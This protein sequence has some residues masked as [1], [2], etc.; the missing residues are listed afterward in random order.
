M[1]LCPAPCRGVVIPT[2][3]T[4]HHKLTGLMGRQRSRCAC[5]IPTFTGLIVSYKKYSVIVS[6]LLYSAICK[7]LPL[8]LWRN[9]KVNSKSWRSSKACVSF[10]HSLLDWTDGVSTHTHGRV[11]STSHSMT[12]CGKRCSLQSISS[13]RPSSPHLRTYTLTK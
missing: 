7:G 2:P 3:P 1:F 4:A 10:R 5:A 13:L 6:I 8:R 11:I 9:K 12:R